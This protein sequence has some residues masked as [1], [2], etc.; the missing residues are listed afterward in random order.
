WA[1]SSYALAFVRLEPHAL[2]AARVR[3][4]LSRVDELTAEP[5]IAGAHPRHFDIAAEAGRAWLSYS[6]G[7]LY[8]RLLDVQP[9]GRS[10]A[11]RR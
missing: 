3:A 1:G 4:D 5:I 11:A 9:V 10:R 2:L 8:L 7:R 6:D